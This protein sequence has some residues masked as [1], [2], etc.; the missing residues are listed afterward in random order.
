M[1][2]V[3]LN[4]PDLSRLTNGKIY[5]DEHF[6]AF[7]VDAN[8]QPEFQLFDNAAKAIPE[9]IQFA[10]MLFDANVHNPESLV[11][12]MVSKVLNDIKPE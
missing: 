3:K 6:S 4:R 5:F 8:T 10:E 11:F 7:L 2:N 12:K 1:E 9:L